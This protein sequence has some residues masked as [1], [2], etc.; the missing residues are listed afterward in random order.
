MNSPDRYQLSTDGMTGGQET[1]IKGRK[2]AVGRQE[3]GDRLEGSV[4]K[5]LRPRLRKHGVVSL[6]YPPPHFRLRPMCC[7]KA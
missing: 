2:A 3:R 4:L 5:K 1:W 7:P 6:S